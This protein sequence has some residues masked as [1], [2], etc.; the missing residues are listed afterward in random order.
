M[1]LAAQPTRMINRFSVA[2]LDAMSRKLAAVALGRQPPDLVITG[3]RILSTYSE[4]VLEEREVWIKG[5]RIA[6]VKPAGSYPV[7]RGDR[8]I[9]YDARGGILAPGLIDADTHLFASRMTACAYAETALLN[10]TTTIICDCAEIVRICDGRALNWFLSDA[11]MAPFSIFVKLPGTVA[12]LAAEGFSQLLKDWPE[13]ILLATELDEKPDERA[14]TREKNDRIVAAELKHTRRLSGDARLPEHIA[15]GTAAGWG[16]TPGLDDGDLA[17]ECLEAGMWTL[18]RCGENGFLSDQTELLIRAVAE[19][20]ASSK[21]ICFCT[22]GGGDRT[23]PQPGVDRVVRRAVAAGVNPVEAWS[24]GSLHAAMLYAMDGEIGGIGPS[25]RADL[26]LLND[27]FE[28]QNTWYG[29]ELVVEH[30]KITAVLDRTLARRFQYPK[31]AYETVKL[32]SGYRLLPEL[33]QERTEANGLGVVGASDRVE[34][35]KIALEPGLGWAGLLAAHGLCFMAVLERQ[36]RGGR[37]GHGLL[38]GF[39]LEDGAVASSACVG[40]TGHIVA[41]SNEAD[42]RL[43][44]AELKGMSGGMCIVRAGR[45]LATLVLPVGGIL[46]DQRA[47]DVVRQQEV[48]AHA[49]TE[50]GCTLSCEGFNRLTSRAQSEIRITF[51]GLNLLPDFGPVAL[52]ETKS[53]ATSSQ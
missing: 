33:P 48:F 34:R 39:G 37:I 41:G 17:A 9:R 28:V 11:R 27:D 26:V 51:E 19:Q 35:R 6:A 2:P 23:S 21:R 46:S 42:M 50:Q 1:V 5:G 47:P 49:W 13:V 45:V 25:R 14:A 43:A 12:G 32:M 44:L 24:I 52:F 16:V 4:R 15:A 53:S 29:G 36:G 40:V 8:T 20:G 38:Q 22:G 18:L 3:A 30:K 7:L 10:G 31:A